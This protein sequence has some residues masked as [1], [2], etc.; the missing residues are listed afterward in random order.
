[1]VK[2]KSKIIFFLSAK[3]THILQAIL[4]GFLM[5]R[6]LRKIILVP[7]S[8]TIQGRGAEKVYSEF[9]IKLK[10]VYD[11]RLPILTSSNDIHKFREELSKAAV[12]LA[13][14]CTGGVKSLIIELAK[15]KR[16]LIILSHKLQNSLA[17]ALH[18]ATILRQR[19]YPVII[20]HDVLRNEES[21]KELSMLVKAL[22]ELN[23]WRGEKIILFGIDEEWLKGEGY[24]IEKLREIFG[25][26]VM[27]M[28]LESFLVS[29]KSVST[30]DEIFEYFVNEEK[31]NVADRDIKE[32]TKIYSAVY[33]FMTKYNCKALGIRCFPIILRASITPCLAV[34]F[35]LD[36]G[37]PTACEADLGALVTMIFLKS[38]TGKIPFMGNLNDLTTE[39]NEIVLAHCTIATKIT[40]KIILKK[41]F[42]TELSVSIEG[43]LRENTNVTIA[44]F[45]NDF[46]TL[47]VGGGKI[48]RGEPWSNEFCRT[49]IRIKLDGN[50]KKL[51]IEPIGSHLVM[52]EGDY[53]ELLVKLATLIGI[54]PIKI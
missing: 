27:T 37:T 1:M 43:H 49:Q 54:K 34:S 21:I 53:R 18:A 12:L 6:N 25:L 11:L 39:D 48:V 42:E 15:F 31:I 17:S 10:E 20:Y 50:V 19:N 14:V 41:H 40:R 35:L 46:N 38:A 30:N 5:V 29:V 2:N 16:P 28:D 23:R 36:Q 8:S 9:S 7:L 47:L 33:D 52:V 22:R 32:A 3:R 4:Y 45:S 13:L 51:I 44:R 24:D 26:N